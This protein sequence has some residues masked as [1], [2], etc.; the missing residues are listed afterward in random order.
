M[1]K[2]KEEQKATPIHSKLISLSQNWFNF[3]Y[4]DYILVLLTKK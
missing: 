3:N 4:L 1:L 2:I